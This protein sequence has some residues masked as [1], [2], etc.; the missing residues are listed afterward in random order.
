L[1]LGRVVTWKPGAGKGS[2]FGFIKPM[3]L[4]GGADVFVHVSVCERCGVSLKVGDRV[5]Y[6]VEMTQRGWQVSQIELV[7]V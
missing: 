7:D 5:R 1:A 4:G 6:E 3:T 2:G